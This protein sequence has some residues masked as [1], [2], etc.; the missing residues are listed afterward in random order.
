MNKANTSPFE[1]AQFCKL[2]MCH[3][4]MSL[5][6]KKSNLALAHLFLLH[7]TKSLSHSMTLNSKNYT[8]TTRIWRVERGFLMIISDFSFHFCHFWRCCASPFLIHSIHKAIDWNLPKGCFLPSWTW[9]WI[10]F[11]LF[12]KTND[13]R[14]HCTMLRKNLWILYRFEYK[15]IHVMELLLWSTM[16]VKE[17]RKSLPRKWS[18]I[19]SVWSVIPLLLLHHQPT[20]ASFPGS[21]LHPEVFPAPGTHEGT[22]R[23]VQFTLNASKGDYIKNI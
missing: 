2:E 3:I 18:R 22:F 10:L 17:K 20:S 8:F 14:S 19:I 5:I 13:V 21:T 16:L 23:V 11:F 12:L 9:L 7:F 6:F 15:M 4:F 1:L